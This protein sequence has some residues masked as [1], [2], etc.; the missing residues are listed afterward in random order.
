MIKLKGDQI[1]YFWVRE[2]TDKYLFAGG[3]SPRIDK[4][5]YLTGELE[6]SFEIPD[7]KSTFQGAYCEDKEILAIASSLSNSLLV[8]VSTNKIIDKGLTHSRGVF[9]NYF[10]KKDLLTTGDT[11]SVIKFYDIKEQKRERK[12]IKITSHLSKIFGNR[13]LWG[14]ITGNDLQLYDEAD[15][16]VVNINHAPQFSI[17]D[18]CINEKG[19]KLWFIYSGK[20]IELKLDTISSSN[21]LHLDLWKNRREGDTK[22]FKAL[23]LIGKIVEDELIFHYVN[24]DNKND[25]IYIGGRD[26]IFIY[27]AE[28]LEVLNIIE[29]PK[30]LEDNGGSR[31][32]ALNVEIGNKKVFVLDSY[33]FRKSEILVYDKIEK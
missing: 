22:S 19:T 23:E 26:K 31:M 5:N 32:S 9:K 6:L 11:K 17:R 8:D 28:T 10:I 20:L 14:T 13:K 27:D 29:I 15:C 2:V 12:Q 21:T 7:A 18:S 1:N 4:W 30:H 33:S 16:L 24:Y 3:N 25:T